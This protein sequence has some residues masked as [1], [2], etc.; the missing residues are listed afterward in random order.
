M[1]LIFG[2]VSIMGGHPVKGREKIKNGEAVNR[3]VEGISPIYLKL[4]KETNN[5]L[6]SMLELNQVKS[7]FVN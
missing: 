4:D 3:R 5:R 6:K 2:V 1:G 7:V